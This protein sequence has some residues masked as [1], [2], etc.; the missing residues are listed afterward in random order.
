MASGLVA[1]CRSRYPPTSTTTYPRTCQFSCCRWT[2]AKIACGLLSLA[3]IIAWSLP[4]RDQFTRAVCVLRVRACP[5]EGSLHHL[6]RNHHQP[7]K[8]EPHLG[9]G[10]HQ[11]AF[12]TKPTL[13]GGEISDKTVVAAAAGRDMSLLL[14]DTV[15]APS[16]LKLAM[17]AV[18][19]PNP[20]FFSF[21]FGKG[22]VYSMGRNRK[23]QL[24]LGANVSTDVSTPTEIKGLP[25]N[26][27]T[28]ACSEY[29]A[30]ALAADGKLF[31]FG[32]AE[33][34]GRRRGGGEELLFEPV[35]IRSFGCLAVKTVVAA[36]GRA[37]IV[38]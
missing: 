19:S 15:G 17:I 31:T 36:G 33:G 2:W 3:W 30:W 32:L 7:G 5:T 14:T 29:T 1:R 25:G 11:H 16:V 26:V 8:G 4:Q 24:G 6:T 34:H 21:F 13:V 18:A 12:V 20:T 27:T 22:A 28:V 38:L 37:Y 9:L 23:G 10:A 35:P